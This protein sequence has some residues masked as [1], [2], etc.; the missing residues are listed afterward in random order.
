MEQFFYQTINWSFAL[1]FW[2]GVIW[3]FLDM[4]VRHDEK[5]KIR[6]EVQKYERKIHHK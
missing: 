4:L 2:G 5:E 6:I 3:F 1:V